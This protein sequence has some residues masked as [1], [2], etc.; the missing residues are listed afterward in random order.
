VTHPFFRAARPLVFAHRGGAGLA[1]ENTLVAFD[2][3]LASGADG[4]EIDVHLSRD[5][6]VVVHHD[7]T[8]D[9]T[10]DRRGDIGAFTVAELERMDAGYRFSRSGLFPFRGQGIGVPTLAAVLARYR[11]TRIIIEMKQD[12][13][14]LAQATVELVRAADAVERVCLGAF[15]W[16]VLRAARALEPAVASGA[17]RIEVRWALWRSRIGWPVRHVAYDG[18]QVPEISKGRR[19]VSARFV[20]H[21]RAAGLP[22]QVWTVDRV[23]DARR[24][25]GWQVHALITD[26]PDV[27]VPL[28][29]D[30]PG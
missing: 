28:V 15:G 5:G 16:R 26:R 9:R 17:S 13:P 11:E 23:E 2:Q 3:G 6:V 14:A 10:T 21:A 25:L 1:P 20:A 8:V 27:I 19:V 12:D 22:V 18:Y 4:L 29:A 24:L 7:P 30:P